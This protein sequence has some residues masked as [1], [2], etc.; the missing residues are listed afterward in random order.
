MLTVGHGQLNLSQW[1]G[2]YRNKAIGGA[3]GPMEP[4]PLPKF[5]AYVVILCFERRCP[6]QNT[7]ARLKSNILTA[8]QMI[9]LATPLDKNCEKLPLSHLLFLAI[10]KKMTLWHCSILFSRLR[11][12]VWKRQHLHLW[13]CANGL[14]LMP[15][16]RHIAEQVE[17]VERELSDASLKMQQ[18]EERRLLDAQ[19]TQRSMAAR[20]EQEIRGSN[21]S[22]DEKEKLL[23]EHRENVEKMEVSFLCCFVLFFWVSEN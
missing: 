13:H 1:P 17:A 4:C 12:V 11:G 21:L 19:E 15:A 16:N 22:E 9:G 5:L 7:V 14:R 2:L 3:R 20:R 23:K 6:K 18:E 10:S 8:P